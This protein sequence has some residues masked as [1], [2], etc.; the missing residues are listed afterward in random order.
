MLDAVSGFQE[1]P[2]RGAVIHHRGRRLVYSW[3][4]M[5]LVI[6]SAARLIGF[7]DIADHLIPLFALGTFLAFKL[8][9]GGMVA[10]WRK[11]GGKH[12]GKSMA[13]NA[14]G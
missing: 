3:G 13:I 14:A 7:G 12:A 6:L 2:W 9:Q 10:H 5:V 8:S 4:I 1:R 11:V